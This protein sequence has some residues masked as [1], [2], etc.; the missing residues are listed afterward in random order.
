MAFWTYILQSESCGRYYCGSTSDLQRRVEQHNNLERPGAI[1]T[2]RYPGPWRL[3]WYEE[4]G[5][6]S[7]AMRREKQ[8]KKRGINRF[9]DDLDH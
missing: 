4:H 6:R 2:A 8:I 1:T 5:S 7:A 3:V 9:L